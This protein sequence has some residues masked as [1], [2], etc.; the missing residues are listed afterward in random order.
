[1]SQKTIELILL[2]QLSSYLNIP[3]FMVDAKGTLVFYNV[4]AE[5]ILGLPFLDTG[6]MSIEEW[7]ALFKLV[8]QQGKPLHVD[9]WPLFIALNHYKP[10]HNHFYIINHQKEI[11][12][13]EMFAYPLM[14]E[15]E[16][17]QGAAAF[18]W[19]IS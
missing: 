19:E 1:M 2:R 8:D 7:S 13:I 18:F 15:I 11:K 14:N 17:L 10:A 4:P 6:E 5:H 12:H 3:A 16:K 9:T